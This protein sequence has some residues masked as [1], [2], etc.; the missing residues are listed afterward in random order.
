MTVNFSLFNIDVTPVGDA[1][2]VCLDSGESFGATN[3]QG[4]LRVQVQG[5]SSP[6]C[7]F[8]SDCRTAYF[9]T[10]DGGRERPFWFAQVVRGHEVDSAQRQ[11][12]VVT[13]GGADNATAAE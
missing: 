12:Q 9:Q 8:Q 11:I 13:M 10:K 5:R 3:A 6:G 7:G 2:L 4:Q 1:T